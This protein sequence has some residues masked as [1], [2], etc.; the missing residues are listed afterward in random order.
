MVCIHLLK[1][2]CIPGLL[3]AVEALP[4][5]KSDFSTLDHLLDRAVYHGCATSEDIQYVRSVVDLP[6]VSTSINDRRS[7]FLTSFSRNFS[8][9]Q[10]IL[11]VTAG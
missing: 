8:W 10:V 11:C 7:K 1:S 3:H 9:A 6:C 2:V 4:L 5:S